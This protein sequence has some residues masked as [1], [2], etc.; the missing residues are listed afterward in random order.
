MY[1]FSQGFATLYPIKWSATL[2][3]VVSDSSSDEYFPSAG[4][5]GPEAVLSNAHLTMLLL[6]SV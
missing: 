5:L 2:K 4:N 3:N 1:S 6:Q